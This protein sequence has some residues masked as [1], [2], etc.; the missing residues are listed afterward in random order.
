MNNSLEFVKQ[1]VEECSLFFYTL[2]RFCQNYTDKLNSRMGQKSKLNF[3]KKSEDIL[4]FSQSEARSK[5]ASPRVPSAYILYFRDQAKLIKQDHKYTHYDGKMLN[6]FIARKWRGCSSEEKKE[7]KDKYDQ[8]KNKKKQAD[9]N[10][11]SELSQSDGEE[12][13]RSTEKFGDTSS[14][15]SVD[16]FED[17]GLEL[18]EDKSAKSKRNKKI[19]KKGQP[20]KEIS[21]LD[22]FASALKEHIKAPKGKKSNIPDWNVS[23]IKKR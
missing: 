6:S 8:L 16:Q 2:H 3:R 19:K 4:K 15:I 23:K 12:K 7:Y 11:M 5:S 14:E 17:L 9:S 20:T 13:V 21:G 10:K 1:T 18:S 22:I